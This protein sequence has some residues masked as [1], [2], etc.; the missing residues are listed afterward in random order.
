MGLVLGFGLIVLGNV[1]CVELL[2]VYVD[3]FVLSVQSVI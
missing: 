3:V 1:E 2:L